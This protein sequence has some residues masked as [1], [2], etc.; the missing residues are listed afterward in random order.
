V[1]ERPGVPIDDGRA[2]GAH[3]VT[4]A[5]FNCLSR[6]SDARPE[7]CTA[8]RFLKVGTHEQERQ[9]KVPSLRNV[10]ER[11]VYMHAGQFTTLSQVLNHYNTAP[12]APAGHSELKPLGLSDSEL[13]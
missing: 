13:R 10:A 5:E 8:L 3:K 2:S 6:W 4:E 9:F 7:D 1:P 12:E 11:R